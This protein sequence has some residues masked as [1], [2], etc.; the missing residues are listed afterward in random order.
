MKKKPNKSAK[1]S[2]KNAPALDC[3]QIGCFGDDSELSPQFGAWNSYDKNHNGKVWVFQIFCEGCRIQYRQSLREA[4]SR[5][6]DVYCDSEELTNKKFHA[7]IKEK[8]QEGYR[9]INVKL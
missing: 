7:M 5:V 6:V 3:S 1:H 4:K 2:V 8:E 9:L